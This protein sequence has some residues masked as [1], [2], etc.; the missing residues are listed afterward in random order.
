MASTSTGQ[1]G[2]A[3]ASNTLEQ[4]RDARKELLVLR[5]DKAKY[6]ELAK[7]EETERKRLFLLLCQSQQ[8]EKRKDE[9][10]ERLKNQIEVD[11]ERIAHQESVI[12]TNVEQRAPTI[13][14]G[15]FVVGSPHAAA[16]LIANP[17]NN[18]SPNTTFFSTSPSSTTE[19]PVSPRRPD[20]GERNGLLYG[21]F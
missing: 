4:L 2:N 11:K 9:E 21:T 14:G 15:S 7:K 3:Q 12:A 1:Y 17:K 13:V 5:R 20:E 6:K 18:L 19:M 10:I 16:D 8:R